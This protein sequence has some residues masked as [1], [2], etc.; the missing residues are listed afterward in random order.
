MSVRIAP[1]ILSADFARL[2][3]QIAAVERGGADLLHLDVMDGHFVP[4]LT[5]G[6][7]MCRALRKHFP[8]TYLDVHLMVEKPAD[9]VDMFAEAGADLFSFHIE[10]CKPLRKRG[11]E[12]DALIERIHKLGMQAGLVVNPPTPIASIQPWLGDVDLVLIM[13]VNPGRAGQRFIPAA[14][15]K[16]RWIKP[17]LS[18]NQRLEMDGGLNPDT[19]AQAVAAGVDVLVTASALFGA[20]DRAEVIRQ[21]HA[22]GA[23]RPPDASSP[24]V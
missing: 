23:D 12:P 16:A 17:K 15:D 8:D 4:N 14:L 13:S 1:S 10:V 24:K 7:D 18:S 22:A 2:G 19:A 20:Q 9:F 3:E 5:M 6:A 21:M 11:T